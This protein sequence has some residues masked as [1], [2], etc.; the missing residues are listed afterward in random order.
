MSS[1]FR[2]I[3]GIL[4]TG[5]LWG[6]LGAAAGTTIGLVAGLAFPGV[7]IGWAAV[8]GAGAL[9]LF[10]L[11]AGASFAAALSVTDGRRTLGQLSPSKSAVLGGLMGAVYSASL[12]VL[13]GPP[14]ELVFLLPATG[15]FGAIGASL[16][17]GS[18]LVARREAVEL[19]SGVGPMLRGS[20]E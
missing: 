16:A 18:I 11:A 15:L 5:T 10:G 20:D 9:G 1:W 17:A 4:G 14:P 7:P 3:R 8:N 6:A 19:P 12:L 13:A 2:R